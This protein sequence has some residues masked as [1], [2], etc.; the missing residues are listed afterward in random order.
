MPTDPVI[1]FWPK[2][3]V[4]RVRDVNEDSYLVDGALT[5]LDQLPAGKWFIVTLTI[6]PATTGEDMAL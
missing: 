2:T 1:R 5:A 4:G 6:A 3:D